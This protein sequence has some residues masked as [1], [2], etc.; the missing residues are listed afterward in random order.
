VKKQALEHAQLNSQSSHLDR[1]HIPIPPPSAFP[2][3]IKSPAISAQ[4][5]TP[6]VS[7][8]SAV[9]SATEV[10]K[11]PGLPTIPQTPGSDTPRATKGGGGTAAPSSVSGS[12]G[13]GD[14]KDEKKEE[15]YFTQRSRSRS[16][17]QSATTPG[18]STAAAGATA[19]TSPG[20]DDFNG[21]GG[22]PT[23]GGL[24]SGAMGVIGGIAGGKG[25]GDG[26][27]TGFMSRLKPWNLKALRKGASEKD[28]TSGSGEKVCIRV[29]ASLL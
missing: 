9:G 8:S 20:A 2:Q 10:S 6:S 25:G 1:L 11:S 14:K 27:G 12:G 15:D 22:P 17:A 26:G 7:S 3:S 19:S 18:A 5:L 28:A 13:G 4:P 23:G 21:W 29:I 24:V 16:V